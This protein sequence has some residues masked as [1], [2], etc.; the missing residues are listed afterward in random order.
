M[1]PDYA[2]DQYAITSQFMENTLKNV[3]KSIGQPLKGAF[4]DNSDTKDS[5]NNYF[6]EGTGF[7]DGRK[8]SVGK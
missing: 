2:A 5:F 4:N 6:R 7:I 1:F 3:G 8:Y